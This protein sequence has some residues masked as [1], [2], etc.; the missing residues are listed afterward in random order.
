MAETRGIQQALRQMCLSYKTT[1]PP[2]AMIVAP[3]SSNRA[4]VFSMWF[5]KE[6]PDY[7][8]PM[9]LGDGPDGVILSDTYMDA[10]DMIGTGRILDT[11]PHR[12]HSA[13]DMFGVS[14]INT[15]NVTLYDACTDAMD[16]ITTGRILDASSPRP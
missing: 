5:P 13:L 9:D 15:D 12:P 4:S 6:V 8:L 16:M 3:P 2:E 11:T 10:M 1:E 14:M 7:D